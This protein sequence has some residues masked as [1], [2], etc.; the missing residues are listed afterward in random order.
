MSSDKD[1]NLNMSDLTAGN[2]HIPRTSPDSFVFYFRFIE[3]CLFLILVCFVAL[4]EEDRAG[5]VNALKVIFFFQFGDCF[6]FLCL[7]NIF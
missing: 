6:L 7:S 3:N 2:I 1:N 5:L 4:N